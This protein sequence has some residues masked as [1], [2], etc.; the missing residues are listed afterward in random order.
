MK[1]L[2]PPDGMTSPTPPAQRLQAHASVETSTSLLTPSPAEH[3]RRSFLSMH[4]SSEVLQF[5]M[6]QSLS[7]V[8]HSPRN[9][10]AIVLQAYS[11]NSSVFTPAA[12]LNTMDSSASLRALE[13]YQQRVDKK[14]QQRR[15]LN[16]FGPVLIHKA[17]LTRRAMGLR[18]RPL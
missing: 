2:L 6:P 11:F 9:R 3:N 13:R 16:L 17:D 15:A 14:K 8:A 12:G 4:R 18:A 10:G 7:M 1:T 5:A